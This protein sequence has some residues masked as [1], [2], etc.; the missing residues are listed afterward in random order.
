[1]MEMMFIKQVVESINF[2]VKIPMILYCDNAGAMDLTRSYSTGGW[3][4]HIDVRHQY[5]RKLIDKG[6]IKIEF[7]STDD[8]ISDIFTEVLRLGLYNMH[9]NS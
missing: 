5:I 3:T 9:S 4:K 7:V 8:N 6:F 1:M 2:E